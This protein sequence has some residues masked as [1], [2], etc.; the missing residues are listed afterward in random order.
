MTPARP[1]HGV[2]VLALSMAFASP[3]WAQNLNAPDAAR[4]ALSAAR[5]AA[6]GLP[7]RVAGAE[8]APPRAAID[9]LY[10]RIVAGFIA[11]LGHQDPAARHRA[12]RGLEALDPP[13]VDALA[14]LTAR[15]DGDAK[16]E[17]RLAS[18]R[19]LGRIL[20]VSDTPGRPSQEELRRRLDELM[21]R[22]RWD[23]DGHYI[24]PRPRPRP[25]DR[26]ALAIRTLSYA[27][28]SDSDARCRDAARAATR[29]LEAN[30]AFVSGLAD[31]LRGGEPET[32]IRAAAALSQMGPSAYAA[33]PTIV[34]RIAEGQPAAVRLACIQAL[35]SIATQGTAAEAVEAL[36][37]AMVGDPDEACRSAAADALARIRARP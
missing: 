14:A 24:E 19:A 12:A 6:A 16:A 29:G 23:D 32:A 15:V 37:R 1:D 4:N 27:A 3:A 10:D 18:I 11:T 13:P 9:P 31:A 21:G 20:S 35:G 36:A 8:L 34:G 7:S 17:V 5:Q 2:F 25:V 22:R 28:I 26:R 33:I 30:P